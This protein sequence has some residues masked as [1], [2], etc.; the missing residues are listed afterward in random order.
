MAS[1]R[2]QDLPNALNELD[3]GGTL[4]IFNL[5]G[6]VASGCMA[7]CSVS[8]HAGCICQPSAVL[9]GEVPGWWSLTLLMGVPLIRLLIP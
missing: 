9:I 7:A 8:L 1:L 5:F 2:P 6:G 4:S 3:R